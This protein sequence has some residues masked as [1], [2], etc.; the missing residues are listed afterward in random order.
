[1][2]TSPNPLS[3]TPMKSPM[4]APLTAPADAHAVEKWRARCRELELEA[5]RLSGLMRAS[6]GASGPDY[7]SVSKQLLAVEKEL[8]TAQRNLSVAMQHSRLAAS[9]A[10]A[11]DRMRSP[12]LRASPFTPGLRM[13][14]LRTSPAPRSVVRSSVRPRQ[15]TDSMPQHRSYSP[16]RSGSK[17]SLEEPQ[18][19]EP[20]TISHVTDHSNTF[21]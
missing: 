7:D 17:H 15:R 11:K 16:P 14:F 12:S 21:I 20:T 2:F 8:R 19:Q 4:L 1:M 13:D 3:M 9:R 10:G 5:S 6:F 18:V